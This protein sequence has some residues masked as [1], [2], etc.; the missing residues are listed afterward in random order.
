M[1]E[2]NYIAM[3]NKRDDGNNRSKFWKE[4]KSVNHLV[5]LLRE[6]SSGMFGVGRGTA[7]DPAEELVR[8]ALDHPHLLERVLKADQIYILMSGPIGLVQANDVGMS[9]QN[10]SGKDPDIIWKKIDAHDDEDEIVII[11][12]VAE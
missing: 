6:C 8:R 1:R 5:D 4:D 9:V 2:E 7:A 10:I 11:I 12:C 3:M